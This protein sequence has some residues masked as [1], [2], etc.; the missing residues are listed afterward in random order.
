MKLGVEQ[1]VCK[2]KDGTQGRA[3][4]IAV[5]PCGDG[6]PHMVLRVSP[7]GDTMSGYTGT[8]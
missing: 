4:E 8:T 3:L 5:W 6:V 2:T 7:I 1:G